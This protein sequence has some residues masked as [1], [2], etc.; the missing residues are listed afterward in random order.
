MGPGLQPVGARFLNFFLGKV[1]LQFILHGMSIFHDIQMATF[2][3]TAWRY[4][5]MVGYA[6]SPTRTVYVGVILTR[7][8]VKVNITGLLNFRQLAKPCMLAAM[9]AAPLWGFL[10]YYI[11]VHIHQQFFL[12]RSNWIWTGIKAAFPDCCRKGAN[13]AVKNLRT[14][15]TDD[16]Q[17]HLLRPLP[18]THCYL[19]C[20]CRHI[21]VFCLKQVTQVQKDTLCLLFQC[22]MSLNIWQVNYDSISI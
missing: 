21:E 3:G 18:S 13:A 1:S 9:T 15:I 19:L 6:G 10:V 11:H 22:F 12:D 7:S 16:E 17:F 14:G 2:F 5:H 8:K 20:L 4:S